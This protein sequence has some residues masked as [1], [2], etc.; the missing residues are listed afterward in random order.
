M[1]SSDVQR[2]HISTSTIFRFFAVILGLVALYLVRDIVF[3]LIFAVIVASAV[4]PSIE[5][6]KRRGIARI[7][8]VIIIY[9]AFALLVAF[10]MYLVLPLMV[11]ELRIAATTF[12]KLQKQLLMGV[13][14]LS[15]PALGSFF[16]EN[17]DLFSRMPLQYLQVFTKGATA[18]GSQIFGGIFSL[19]LIFVFSFYLATQEKGIE[20]F[21]KMVTPLRYEPYALDLWKRSQQKLGR[22]LRAQMLLGAVVGVFIFI[23]LTIL[24]VEQAFL[25]AILAGMFEIIPVVGPILAAVPAVIIAFLIS[26]ILGV[27]TIMLFLV[28]QQV[29]SHV[30]VPIVMKKAVGLSPLVVVVAL[31]VGVKIGGIFGILLAVP[32]T[33]IFAELLNDWEKKK[34]TLIPE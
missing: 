25:L 22:W 23:G 31:L 32:L 14:Q 17:V 1:L 20:G 21:L 5:W 26:P 19:G 2:I 29:E 16:T 12:T 3:S 15:G 24:G 9:T 11:D 28:V 8:G 4:E 10:L 27:S 34:R 33:T 30:I 6:L 7:L 13:R 18:V